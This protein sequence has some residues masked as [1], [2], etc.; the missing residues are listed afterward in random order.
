MR[1]YGGL[2]VLLFVFSC[3]GK[4]CGGHKNHNMD[5][6]DTQF[7]I[8]EGVTSPTLPFS[9]NMVSY[10]KFLPV[11]TDLVG[12][13][14]NDVAIN[15]L[16]TILSEFPRLTRGY[17]LEKLFSTLFGFNPLLL[18]KPCG[19]AGIHEIGMVLFCKGNTDLEPPRNAIKWKDMDIS[20]YTINRNDME[21][22]LANV[23]DF[24]IFGSREMINRIILVKR[25]QWP[26]LI[27]AEKRWIEK[28]RRC[29]GILRFGNIGIFF[30]SP[31]TAPW[32]GAFCEATCMS[33]KTEE[34]A[35]MLATSIPN[36][37]ENLKKYLSDYTTNLLKIFEDIRDK[38]SSQYLRYMTSRAIKLADIP[39]RTVETE[40]RG[41][42]IIL[43]VKGEV[44]MFVSICYFGYIEKILQI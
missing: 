4:G 35:V 21:I 25:H 3:N 13:F 17:D 27:D 26:S 28:L 14:D 32:C 11:Q 31:K 39:A 16:K 33:I 24:F 44:L 7:G 30:V 9:E 29:E 42:N 22:S 12:I 23:E 41:E 19:I 36:N 6:K 34:G 15:Y 5:S 18:G 43:K 2:V 40:T 37:L 1:Y 38:G 8:V 20:G 10:A